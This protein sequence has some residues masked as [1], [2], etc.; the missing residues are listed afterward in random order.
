M[1]VPTGATDGQQ[2]RRL[3]S[4]GG[5]GRRVPHDRP[6]GSSQEVGTEEEQAQHELRQSEPSHALLLR[7]DDSVQGAREKVYLQVS[8]RKQF[9]PTAAPHFWQWL[10]VCLSGCLSLSGGLSCCLSACLSVSLCLCIFLPACLCS[11]IFVSVCVCLSLSF[12][13]D[14]SLPPPHALSLLSKARY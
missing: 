6:G 4:L 8:Q 5:R 13:Q 1:A 11:S 2:Q 10:A 9:D 7:Q 12:S 3:H 14:L